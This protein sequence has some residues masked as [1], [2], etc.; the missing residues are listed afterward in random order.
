[1]HLFCQ[2]SFYVFN[3]FSDYESSITIL[4]KTRKYQ[5]VSQ[6]KENI[7][8]LLKEALLAICCIFLRFPCVYMCI[9]H[10]YFCAL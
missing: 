1:M 5:K 10:V 7:M 8:Q 4:G 6:R 9:I 3:P 2:K